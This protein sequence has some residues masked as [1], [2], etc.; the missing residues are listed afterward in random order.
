MR[1]RLLLTAAIAVSIVGVGAAP[2]SATCHP[3]KPSTCPPCRITGI[4]FDENGIPRIATQ[5]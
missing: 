2:A 5:C 3:E 4:E 1:I